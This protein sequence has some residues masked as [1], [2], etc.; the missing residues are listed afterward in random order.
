MDGDCGAGDR[1]DFSGLGG[2]QGFESADSCLDTLLLIGS[3]GFS[4]EWLCGVAGSVAGW[5]EGAASVEESSGDCSEGVTSSVS[6]ST[7]LL[8][9]L[10]V[11]K[12]NSR[13]FCDFKYCD[14]NQL[15]TRYANQSQLKKQTN[16]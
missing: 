3:F 9:I 16:K 8:S 6:A 10:A 14:I 11:R 2:I 5:E 4:G 13:A 7:C 15:V 1:V 12:K